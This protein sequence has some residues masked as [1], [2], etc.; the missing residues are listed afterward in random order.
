MKFLLLII[1]CFGFISSGFAQDED[2]AM[3][4][5]LQAQQR[6]QIEQIQKLN[7]QAAQLKEGSES[8]TDQAEFLKKQ[9]ANLGEKALTMD[10][11]MSDEFYKMLEEQLKN[12]PLRQ[13]DKI[14]LKEMIIAKTSD[15]PAGKI[16][17]AVP[18]TLE[19]AVDFL[20]DEKAIMGLLKLVRKKERL[21]VYGFI[22][23]FL[24]LSFWWMKKN[25]IPQELP[26]LQRFFQ[27]TLLSLTGT[28]ISTMTFYFMF[29]Q[30]I[31]PT[32]MIIKK[33]LL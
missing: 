32:W 24:L 18:M 20:Q 17:T 25:L 12:N 2:E 15:H 27:R 1:L 6:K 21:K 11:M 30:E 7:E 13:M 31:Q 19:I 29:R 9:T 28:I 14:L 5:E 26:F 23:L 4:E 8:I 10:D 3:V 16:F 33:H 22:W